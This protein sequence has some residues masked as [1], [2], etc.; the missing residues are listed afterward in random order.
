MSVRSA[1]ADIGTVLLLLAVAALGFYLVLRRPDVSLVWGVSLIIGGLG[2]IIPARVKGALGV[3]LG[4]IRD[5]LLAKTGA[6]A[7]PP[8]PPGEQDTPSE[9]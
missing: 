1:L 6:P 5:V 9:P 4:A 7:A 3:V 2:A 8:S